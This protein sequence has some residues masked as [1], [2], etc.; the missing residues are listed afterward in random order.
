MLLKPCNLKDIKE[1]DTFRSLYC[2]YIE[3]LSVYS[4]RLEGKVSLH[5]TTEIWCASHTEKYFVMQGSKIVGFLLL[6]INENKHKESDWFI[7]EF[8]IK[9]EYQSRNIGTE[10]IKKMLCGKKGRYCFFVLHRNIRA[11]RFWKKVFSECGYIDV[12][13]KYTCSC[14]P[15]DCGFFMFEP[16]LS[17]EKGK[18][19]EIC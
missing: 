3:E 19:Y 11:L 4:E 8:Y 9:K 18:S 16:A 2:D 6:G 7:G 14:T 1:F 13:D 5:E 17:S 15:D 10:V 12:S